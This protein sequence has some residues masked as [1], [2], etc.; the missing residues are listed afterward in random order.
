MA[1]RKA[2]GEAKSAEAKREEAKSE[3]QRPITDRLVDEALED[4]FPA[5]DPPFFV[6]GTTEPAGAAEEQAKPERERHP[7]KPDRD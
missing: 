2:R 5:S 7:A 4:T 3:A 1:A 6:G